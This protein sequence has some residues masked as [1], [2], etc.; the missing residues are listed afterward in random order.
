MPFK[1]NH[2]NSLLILGVGVLLVPCLLWFLLCKAHKV[3]TT[4]M[5]PTVMIGDLVYAEKLSYKIR[6]P[7]RG[8]I[9]LFETHA[10]PAVAKR[11]L[12]IARLIGI[13][14][15]NI[16]FDP[17]NLIVNRKKLLVPQIF[18]KITLCQQGYE[19]FLLPDSEKS[20]VIMIT[21]TN[22]I[23]LGE[24]EYFVVGDNMKSSF[25]SRYW[26]ALPKQNIIGRVIG[27]FR[28]LDPY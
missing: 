26:G 3:T 27:L 10:V 13:P 15:D 20:G 7:K 28:N 4:N 9:V 23:Q 19:G 17:P 14:K 6:E 16:R 2:R 21:K 18:E 22:E 8:E 1:L 25:D 11:R 24:Y 5:M 12:Y